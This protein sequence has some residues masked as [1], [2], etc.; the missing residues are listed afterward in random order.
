MG[1]LGFG[2]SKSNTPV[3]GSNKCIFCRIVAGEIPSYKVYEDEHVMAFL[4]VHPCAKGHTVVIPREHVS[5]IKDMTTESWA[6]L[7]RGL[8]NAILRIEEVIKPAGYNLGVNNRAAAGQAVPHTHWHIIPRYDKDGGG[9][10]HSIIWA[11][12]Q[13]N[14]AETAKLFK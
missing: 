3:P 14:V 2:Q 6:F 9:S 1:I 10:M 7:M 5:D 13:D 11:N 12:V 4:D 8:R